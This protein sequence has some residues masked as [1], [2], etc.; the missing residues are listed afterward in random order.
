MVCGDET[1]VIEYLLKNEMKHSILSP[2]LN[3]SSL[4]KQYRFSLKYL[5]PTYKKVFNWLKDNVNSIIVSDM[6]Y[7]IPMEKMNYKV[8]FIPNPINTHKI[9]FS[10]LKMDEKIIIFLGINRLSYDKKGIHFLKKR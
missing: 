9:L 8:N 4:K 3:D 7:K 2:Y 10:E 1:P 5:Q 6:D